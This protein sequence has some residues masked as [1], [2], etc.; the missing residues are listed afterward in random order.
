MINWGILAEIF[1]FCVFGWMIFSII[2]ILSEST[3][4]HI[5]FKQGR[6]EDSDAAKTR[7]EP[8]NLAVMLG[9]LILIMVFITIKV[10]F[11]FDGTEGDIPGIIL[12][13]IPL[14]P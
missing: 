12:A 6:M 3:R 9:L 7:Q 1:V 13:A 4:H 8:L 2:K 5:L 11:K 14:W 10:G